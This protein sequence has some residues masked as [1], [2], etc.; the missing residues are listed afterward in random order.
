MYRM[1]RLRR[2]EGIRDL[3]R[4]NRLS[5]KELVYPLFVVEGVNLKIRVPSM[6]GVF[7]Y[8]LDRLPELL[9]QLLEAGVNAVLVFGVPLRKDEA[10]S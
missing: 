10:G 9:D 6:P 5:V 8:S 3:V 4:E 7:Q 2:T 1:R